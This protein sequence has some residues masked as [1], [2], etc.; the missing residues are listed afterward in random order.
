M[1]DPSLSW[2]QVVPVCKDNVVALPRQSAHSFGGIGQVCVVNK[3]TQILHLIDPETCQI[4][5]VSPTNYFKLP[6]LALNRF[7]DLVEYTVMNIEP[8]L[9]KDR[10][11]DNQAK[12]RLLELKTM[13]SGIDF[14]GRVRSVT[15]TSWRIAG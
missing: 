12:G 10:Y 9:A 1:V 4:T 15:S 6:F 2:L 7:S 8:V 5:E 14:P 13:C 11:E 3:V